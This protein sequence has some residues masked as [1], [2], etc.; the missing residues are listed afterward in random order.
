MKNF[1]ELKSLWKNQTEINIPIEGTKLI[2]EK[3][4]FVKKKQRIT[5]IV[6]GVTVSILAC[7]FYYIAA[8][9]NLAVTFALLLM[10]GALLIRMLIEFRSIKKLNQINITNDAKEFKERMIDYHKGRINIHYI[11]TPIIVVLYVLGFILLLPFFKEEVSNGFY[12]YIKI[13]GVVTGILL[14]IFIRYHILRE[15]KILKALTE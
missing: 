13:S 6:L 14:T 5:N 11:I 1:E 15:I 4:A 2:I 7:F 12:I 9:S 8:Y 3:V 10:I